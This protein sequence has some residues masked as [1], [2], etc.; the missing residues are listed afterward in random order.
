MKARSP[1]AQCA[2]VLLEQHDP[3]LTAEAQNLKSEARWRRDEMEARRKRDGSETEASWRRDAD[4]GETADADE[5]EARW[6]ME[7]RDG[8]EMQMEA[9]WRRDGGSGGGDEVTPSPKPIIGQ[10]DRSHRYNNVTAAGS[11][12]Q[13]QEC[14]VYWRGTER[15]VYQCKVWGPTCDGKKRHTEQHKREKPHTESRGRGVV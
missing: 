10:E 3:R 9:R 14:K 12:D 11:P 7:A 15:K 1:H 2:V 4:G 13:Q 8:G 6:Q 5:V